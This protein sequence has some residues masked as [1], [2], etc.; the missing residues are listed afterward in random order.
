[1]TVGAPTIVII[2]EYKLPDPGMYECGL[3]RQ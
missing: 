1:M 3:G 2:P